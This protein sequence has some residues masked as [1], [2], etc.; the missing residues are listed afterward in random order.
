[1]PALTRLPVVALISIGLVATAA[2]QS[3]PAPRSKLAGII[4]PADWGASADQV[5]DKLKG[6]LDARYKDELKTSD[7][8]KIDRLM[9]QKADEMKRLRESIVRFDGQRTG[10]ESSL[11]AG[12][13]MPREGEALIRIDDRVAQR[14]FIFR[15]DQLFKVVVTYNVSSTGTFPDFVNS[16]RQKYGNPKKASFTD[17]G[18]ERRMSAVTWEDDHTRLVVQDQSEFYSSYVM[19]FVQVGRGTDLEAARARRPRQRSAADRAAEGMMGDI[20]DSSDEGAQD[21]LVDQITGVEATVDLESGRPQEYAV[22]QMADDTEARPKPKKKRE[23]GK[24]PK[25]APSKPAE[26]AIIY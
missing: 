22:P 2:A 8:I 10:Y 15:D 26:P 23:R 4:H 13:V 5:F 19:K 16:V 24:T 25:K 17:D 9:R 7:T 3:P 14:Y 12:E 6:E 18:G 1:M 11:L 20:F 21:D